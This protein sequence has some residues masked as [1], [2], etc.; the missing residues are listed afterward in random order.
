[1]PQMV[2]IAVTPDGVTFE[3]LGL[4][5][6]WTLK[7]RLTVRLAHITGVRADPGVSLGWGG[8]IRWPGTYIP[9]MIK[10]GTYY[11]R[12]RRTFWDVTH[13]QRAIVIELA[14]DRYDALIVEVADPAAAV[15]RI[16]QARRAAP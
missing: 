15:A 10:A 5:K 3:V 12:G 16:E 14:N 2:D 4:H 13:P 6:L 1:M 8:E 11:G 7:S 9:G